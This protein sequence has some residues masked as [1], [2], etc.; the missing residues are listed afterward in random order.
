QLRSPPPPAGVL[1]AQLLSPPPPAGVLNAQLLSPPP[2]AA[3]LNAQLLSPPPPAGEVGRRSRPG[4]GSLSASGSLSQP[5]P[6][7]PRQAGEGGAR[8][9]RLLVS[10]SHGAR[11]RPPSPTRSRSTSA[12]PATT[13]WAARRAR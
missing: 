3:V 12:S 6:C 10:P 13:S 11:S 1:N 4:G 8:C 5:P 9:A 7:P 2:P